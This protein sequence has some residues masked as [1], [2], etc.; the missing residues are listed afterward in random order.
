MPPQH[1]AAY[2]AC[3][4]PSHPGRAT[5]PSPTQRRRPGS[6]TRRTASGCR[7]G[8]AGTRTR[9]RRRSF[10]RRHAAP[11]TARGSR[12]ADCADN[13]AVGGH[14]LVGD[15]VVAGQA[16][17]RASQPMP[18]PRVRPPTPVCETLPAVVASPWGWVPRRAPP[19]GRRPAPTRAGARTG[20]RAPRPSASGRSSARP[21]ARPARPRCARRSG[22]R[23]PA[24]RSRALA[25]A[26]TTSSASRQRAT[27]AGRRSTIAFHT[28]R[29]SSYP[30]SPATRNSVSAMVSPSPIGPLLSG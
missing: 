20:R 6:R 8:A 23:S 22:R 17:L 24:P 25:I 27:S 7:C 13:V 12:S 2:V 26:A 9:S 11:R 18:P 16:V 4:A 10:R 30:S 21:R 15:D 1:R 19:A 28:R 14:H 29:D 3:G 5:R